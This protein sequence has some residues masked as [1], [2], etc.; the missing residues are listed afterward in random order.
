MGIRITMILV[1]IAVS[2][3]AQKYS[4]FFGTVDVGVISGPGTELI[5]RKT[6]GA[7]LKLDNAHAVIG[8]E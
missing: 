2:A 8:I 7:P 3:S 6:G 4:G 5:T 1:A